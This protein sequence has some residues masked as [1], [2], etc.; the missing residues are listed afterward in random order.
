MA[1]YAVKRASPCQHGV[2]WKGLRRVGVGWGKE[3]PGQS[4]KRYLIRRMSDVLTR[5]YLG[6]ALW[7]T[8]GSYANKIADV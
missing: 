8:Y 6:R 2:P 1:A 3:K 7:R 4:A 5:V